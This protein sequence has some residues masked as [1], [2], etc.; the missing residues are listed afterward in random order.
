[1]RYSIIGTSISEESDFKMASE[2]ID[3][4]E[5]TFRVIEFEDG[6]VNFEIWVDTVEQKDILFN[7][8]KVFIDENGGRISWHECSHWNDVRTPCVI[9][10]DYGG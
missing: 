8:L 3:D 5:D 9:A 2:I 1:M 7:D 6:N 4:I 10:E